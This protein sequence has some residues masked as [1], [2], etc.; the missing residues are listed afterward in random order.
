M[1]V[2]S[3]ADLVKPIPNAVELLKAADA[4]AA[5]ARDE[6]L[7]QKAQFYYHHHHHHHHHGYWRRFYHHHHHHHHGYWGPFY[8][9]HHHHHHNYYYGDGW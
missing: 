1:Q 6:G 4:R 3:Y 7:I 9:H 5:E 8:H 2:S